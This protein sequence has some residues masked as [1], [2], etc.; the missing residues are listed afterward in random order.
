[1]ERAVNLRAAIT[2]MTHKLYTDLSSWYRLVDPPED[3]LEEAGIYAAALL[4]GVTGAADTLLELGA[5][6]GHNGFYMKQRFR[7][8]LTDISPAMQALSRDLN[9][10]CEH[11]AG[12][13]RTLRVG[14]TFDAVFVHDAIVYMTTEDDLTAVARTAFVHTRPGGAA[15]FAPDYLR[16]TFRDAAQLMSADA[17]SRSLRGV[18]WVWDP[19]P[20]DTTY[21][22][23]YALLLRDGDEIQSVHDC[24]VEGL[25][26][27]ATWIAILTGA[28]FQVETTDG[29]PEAASGQVFLGRRLP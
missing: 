7:C 2:A 25:F 18:E 14:R 16:E 26:T 19:D 29:P 9:P 28:G 27:H 23:E 1:M 4:R 13:M 12:D 10:D 20:E 21:R 5:G 8:T 6:A 3:H 17:G 24:H 11:L 15:L 22:A